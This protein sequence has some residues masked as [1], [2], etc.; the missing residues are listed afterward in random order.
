[1]KRLL[2]I[3]LGILCV[4]V[5]SF[6]L[7]GWA[8]RPPEIIGILTSPQESQHG[9]GGN[10]CWVGDQNGDG[11]D[12]LIVNQDRFPADTLSFVYLFNGGDVIRNQPAFTWST[13]ERGLTIGREM[14]Y[15]GRVDD[16]AP[17][18]A[19]LSVKRLDAFNG[20]IAV[21]QYW[22]GRAPSKQPVVSMR[23]IQWEGSANIKSQVDHPKDLNNDGYM[24][25]VFIR[26]TP[27]EPMLQICF[28]GENVD[29][30]PDWQSN[31]HVALGISGATKISG[32]FDVNGDSYDDMLVY[33]PDNRGDIDYYSLYLGGN[34]PD[35]VPALRIRS[36]ENNLRDLF[37][38]LPDVNDDGY[39]DWGISWFIP[40]GVD[41]RS[42]GGVKVFFG[43]EE[44]D[45]EPDLMLAFEPSVGLLIRGLCGGDFN[46]D[47]EGDIVIIETSGFIYS[48]GRMSIYFGKRWI[49]DQQEPDIYVS[50]MMRQY[51]YEAAYQIDAVGD[52]NGDHVDDFASWLSTDGVGGLGVFAGNTHWRVDV[53]KEKTL[54]VKLELVLSVSPNP[55]NQSATIEY[56]ISQ[57]GQVTLSL[58]D[59]KGRFLQSLDS[60]LKKAVSHSASLSVPS[61]GLYILMLQT[62]NQRIA[63]KLVCIK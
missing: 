56:S 16:G 36:D 11:Y 37:A 23:G 51:G 42:E 50:S 7:P 17:R 24:D 6:A 10:F 27:P 54:P 1:M 20:L 9:F 58:Y 55:F 31:P 18:V 63:R 43:G 44:P 59:I 40:R 62:G 21:D 39:D 60:G 29:I 22:L 46:G 52:Y 61:S 41:E 19:F 32:G 3:C 12:D 2:L 28:G 15:L 5:I 30:I 35:T 57:K 49:R 14:V 4:V 26:Q 34:P 47:G 25:F 48:V 53:P 13:Y 45:G 8:Y 33:T 38:M